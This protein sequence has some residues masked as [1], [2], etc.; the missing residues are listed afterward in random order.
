M[1]GVMGT[2]LLSSPIPIT[3]WSTR[4]LPR[5]V[6]RTRRFSSENNLLPTTLR[7]SLPFYLYPSNEEGLRTTCWL[8]LS[9]QQWSTSWKRTRFQADIFM[10]IRNLTYEPQPAHVHVVRVQEDPDPLGGRQLREQLVVAEIITSKC[11]PLHLQIKYK[12]MEGDSPLPETEFSNILLGITGGSLLCTPR[13]F[14]VGLTE[15]HCN[16][17]PC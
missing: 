11:W 9:I 13:W 5:L 7:C 6:E 17:I 2:C 8:L 16:Q 14:L 3:E 15:V 12:C 1:P 10:N 4:V